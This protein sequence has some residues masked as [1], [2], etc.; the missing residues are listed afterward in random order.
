MKKIKKK[1]K[2]FFTTNILLKVGSLILAFLC[3]SAIANAANQVR[4][5]VVR[6]P[7]EYKFE[8]SLEEDYGLA[9]LEEP[10]TIAIDVRV[11]RSDSD[12]VSADDFVAVADLTQNIGGGEE[13]PS[14]RLVRVGELFRFS[15]SF[16]LCGMGL[17]KDRSIC[18]G[19]HGQIYRKTV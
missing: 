14:E 15:R 17:S 13:F 1:L 9:V 5:L 4:T 6:V 3:W 19:N 7:I 16:Y 18:D 12:R 2:E 8:D 11:R 10:E